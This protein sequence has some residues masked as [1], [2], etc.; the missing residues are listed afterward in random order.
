MKERLSVPRKEAF[1]VGWTL[2]LLLALFECFLARRILLSDPDVR[3]VALLMVGLYPIAAGAAGLILRRIPWL[4][5][6]GAFVGAIL[7]LVLSPWLLSHAFPRVLN[8]IIMQPNRWPRAAGILLLVLLVAREGSRR[9]GVLRRIAPQ[10]IGFFATMLVPLAVGGILVIPRDA[11]KPALP[12]GGEDREYS[13]LLL[14]TID[15]LRKDELG[16]YGGPEKN[17]PCIDSLATS[18]LV[19]TRA[20]T[21]SPWTLA[22][23]ANL[24]TGRYP[25]TTGVL[26]GRNRLASQFDTLAEML[27]DQGYHTHAIVTNI[28]LRPEFGLHQ[29]FHVFNHRAPDEPSEGLQHFFGYRVFRLIKHLRSVANTVPLESAEDVAEQTCQLLRGSLP[30]P[31]FLWLHFNDVHDPYHPPREFMPPFEK[32]YR[33]PFR[34]TSGS[35]MMLRQGG[36]LSQADRQ[37]IRSLYRG[38]VRYVDSQLNRVLTSLRSAGL[39]SSTVVVLTSDHGEEF[40]EHDNV[41]HGHTLYNELLEIPLVVAGA[42]IP[43]IGGTDGRACSLVDV[44]PTVL[45][46]LGLACSDELSGQSLLRPTESIDGPQYGEALQFYRE[47][48]SIVHN[49]WKLIW[50]PES[51]PTA[52]FDLQADPG[53]TVNEKDRYPAITLSLSD[54]L[55]AHILACRE[56]ADRLSIQRGATTMRLSPKLRAEL[57]AQ[58][59]IE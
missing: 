48:K 14:I 15:T 12:R 13:N 28:W 34:T 30:G 38:E 24:M 16:C 50:S 57:R 6:P 55:S 17:T 31:F 47:L 20:T 2:G 27:R 53:E 44:V 21:C 54:A 10:H 39:A 26:T 33:G 29:G 18:G 25:S 46:V 32:T 19:F 4:R 52:L 51:G 56:R 59:Y 7:F 3:A 36:R 35:M 37:R 45:D 40:W 1:G 5:K 8:V 41:M 9:P 22:S 11:Q 42:A 58:G 49:G 23:L 43:R